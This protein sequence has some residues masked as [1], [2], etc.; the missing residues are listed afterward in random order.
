[1]A[2][3]QKKSKRETKKPKQTAETKAKSAA[4]SLSSEASGTSYKERFKKK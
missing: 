3:G 1:M 2:K 4:L